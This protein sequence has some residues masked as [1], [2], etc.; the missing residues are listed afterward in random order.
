VAYRTYGITIDDEVDSLLEKEGTLVLT[1]KGIDYSFSAANI[2]QAIEAVRRCS[3][4]ASGIERSFAVPAG[5]E[6]MDA[7]G[8][9]AARLGGSEVDTYL[10]INNKDQVLL[11][12]GRKDWN[13]WSQEIELTLQIDSQPPLSLKGT[14]WSNLVLVLLPDDKDVA[15]LRKASS[16]K[17]QLPSGSYSAKVH[18]VGLAL[19]SVAACTR[20]KRISKSR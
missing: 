1:I 2:P 17:W 18:D 11:M 20:E 10:T 8:G 15:A 14:Q 3:G 4:L 5:W 16:L 9:C 12:A 7:A 13:F 19:D 6:S